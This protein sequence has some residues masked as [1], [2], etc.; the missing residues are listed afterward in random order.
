MLNKIRHKVIAF[1]DSK[2]DIPILAALAAGLYPL[3]YYYNSNFTLV[4]SWSQ[5]FY[6]V[7][8]YLILPSITFFLCYTLIKRLGVFKKYITYLLPILNFCLFAF[9][10]VLSTY[11]YRR[12]IIALAVLGAFILAILL[13]KHLKKIIVFQFILAVLVFVKLIPDFYRHI[14]YSSAWMNQPDAIEDVVFKKRPNIYVIQPDGYANFTELRNKTYNFDNSEFESFLED[15]SF[16]L[17]NNFRSN[18]NSTLSSNGSMFAMKH[19]QYNNPKPGTN[20]VYNSRDIIV[21]ENPVIS[22][23]NKNNYKTSLIL[24]KSYLL[25]N[26]PN[27][28]YD[29]CNIDY[30]EVSYLAR[31]FEVDKNVSDDLELAI[32]NNTATNNFYFIEKIA[33]GHIPTYDW[34]SIGK[35][36]GRLAYLKELQGAN[37]WL[38]DL[39]ERIEKHD[40]NSLIVI[41]ADHGGFVGLDYTLQCKE[42][43]TERDLVYTI[44]TSALAIKWPNEAPSFDNQLKSNVNLFR[45]L[46]S[47]LGDDEQYLNNLQED[48]SYSVIEKGAPYGVYELINEKGEVVFNKF[49]K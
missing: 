46:F 13:R 9:L 23:F 11:G 22:I 15:K 18:Y 12:K 42:K 31:G 45:V 1:I 4:N 39:V 49:S 37:D 26:R 34:A 6:F 40:K 36:N 47:Y 5:F 25:V 38:K 24:E 41:V 16:K 20:E 35:E 7:M 30:S 10:I 19:H 43:Q 32:T 28:G 27:L 2:K 14:T 33:P 3:I 44:F 29:Y 17:Y 8:L 48:K 21:G